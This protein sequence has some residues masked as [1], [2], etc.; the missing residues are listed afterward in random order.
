MQNLNSD[1]DDSRYGSSK[2]GTL[3]RGKTSDMNDS[4]RRLQ[5]AEASNSTK[6]DWSNI[7]G[8][9]PVINPNMKIPL[10]PNTVSR[11]KHMER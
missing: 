6:G 1:S 7:R 9:Y 3:H 2:G 5:Q 4:T 8:S 10:T 11:V